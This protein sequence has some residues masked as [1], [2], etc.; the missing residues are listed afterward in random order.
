MDGHSSERG[1]TAPPVER[2]RVFDAAGQ[3][4]TRDPLA[5]K[6]PLKIVP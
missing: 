1:A 4:T 3:T 6:V 2:L 5:A